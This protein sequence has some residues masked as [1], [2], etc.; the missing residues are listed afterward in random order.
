MYIMQSQFASSILM[1]ESDLSALFYP[2]CNISLLNDLITLL[3]ISQLKNLKSQINSLVA[4]LQDKLEIS[5]ANSIKKL[6]ESHHH[7]TK[8]IYNLD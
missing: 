7:L 5:Q 2:N 6:I 3:N 4:S 1:N 8:I